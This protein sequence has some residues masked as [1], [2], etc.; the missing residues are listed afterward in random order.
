MRYLFATIFG[1]VGAGLAARFLAPWVAP[2]VTGMQSYESPD[3]E[4]FVEQLT[5]IGVM[6]GAL[7]VGWIIGLMVG[8]SL[9]RH[10]KPM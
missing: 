6:L 8:R 3:G 2:L 1:L 10:E 9:E 5:F 4:A 7:L